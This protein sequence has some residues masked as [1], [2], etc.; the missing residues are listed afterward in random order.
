M[1]KTSFKP[2]LVASTNPGECEELCKALE[3]SCYETVEAHRLEHIEESIRANGARVIFL[4]LDS[5]SVDNRFIKKFRTRNP[6]VAIFAI[7][8]R[9]LHPEL[10]E[11]IST[12]IAAC[13]RKP[14]DP[15]EM[16]YLLHSIIKKNHNA[17]ASP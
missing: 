5:F 1:K 14:V 6:D 7:S 2:I 8:S 11:S 10:Q 13:L 17:R 4:D 15:E 9:L 12:E 3:D 16:L